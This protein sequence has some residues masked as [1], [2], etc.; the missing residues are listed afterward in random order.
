MYN[1]IF[2]ICEENWIYMF[3]FVIWTFSR[4]VRLYNKVPGHIKDLENYKFFKKG[5]LILSVAT[6]ISLSG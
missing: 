2:I 1:F 4:K 6:S 3:N 5:V